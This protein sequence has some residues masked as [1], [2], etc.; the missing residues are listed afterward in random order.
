ML[1]EVLHRKQTAVGLRGLDDRLGQFAEIVAVAPLLRDDFQRAR[2]RMIVEDFAKARRAT[3][4]P[5]DF[6]RVGAIFDAR[7]D[8]HPAARGHLVDGE[9]V[10]C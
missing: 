4:R 3:I 7:P 2:Q 1:G 9:A 8:V 10:G 5:I 6:E